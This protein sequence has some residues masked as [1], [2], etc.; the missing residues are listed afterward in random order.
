LYRRS[1]NGGASF[2]STVNLSNSRLVQ[3]P[4]VAASGNNVYVVWYDDT[5][6]NI[7]IFYR[8]STNGG[9]SFGSTANL[10]HSGPWSLNPAVA[11][12]NILT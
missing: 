4:A 5:P 1:T 8:R 6:G 9:A 10:S 2:G 7:D 12:S 3:F 11:A